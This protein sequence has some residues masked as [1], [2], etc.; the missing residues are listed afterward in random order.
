[1]KPTLPTETERLR[2]RAVTMGDVDEFL[3]LHED[4]L[5]ARF[6]G[7]YDREGMVEWMQMG[8]D[9]WAERGHGR[10]VILDRA[11]GEFL[12]RTSLKHWPQFEETEVA[13]A[14]RPEAR[15]K[16]F[17]TEAGAASLRWGF[18]H[19]DLPRITAMIRPE[20]TASVR[21]AERLGLY[22]QRTDTLLG[23]EVVVYAIGREEWGSRSHADYP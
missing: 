9:E 16:G 11:S 8:L 10:V 17:A 22:P 3:A 21:I 18:E 1:M 4:P 7:A 2:F 5:V 15:G 14:L 12:G 13:W 6:M 19:F 23:E 20:N